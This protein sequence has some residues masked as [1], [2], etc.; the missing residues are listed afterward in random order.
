MESKK[1]CAN[2]NPSGK[3]YEGLNNVTINDIKFKDGNLQNLSKIGLD[4]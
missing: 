1:C 4:K 3:I 2:V